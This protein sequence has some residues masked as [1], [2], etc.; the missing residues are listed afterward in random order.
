[1]WQ[2]V[3]WQTIVSLW[4]R[5]HCPRSCFLRNISARPL[6]ETLP[7]PAPPALL[8]MRHFLYCTAQPE[9]IFLFWKWGLS[10]WLNS[11]RDTTRGAVKDSFLLPCGQQVMVLHHSCPWPSPDAAHPAQGSE[12]LTTARINPWDREVAVRQTRTMSTCIGQKHMVRGEGGG[13]R[14]GLEQLLLTNS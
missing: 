10:P 4:R 3:P 11:L 7:V 9:Y 6:P 2:Y 13:S 14:E 5:L 12:S 1:M 8:L